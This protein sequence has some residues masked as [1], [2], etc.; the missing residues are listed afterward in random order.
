MTSTTLDIGTVI[1]I[2]VNR[3]RSEHG[4]RKLEKNDIF[5]S[6]VRMYQQD[7]V[8][9][10]IKICQLT[11]ANP[12]EV[13]EFLRSIEKN[14]P[15]YPRINDSLSAPALAKSLINYLVATISEAPKEAEVSGAP[16]ELHKVE[17][18]EPTPALHTP[19]D[20]PLSLQKLM[21]EGGWSQ[22]TLSEALYVSRNTLTDWIK[23]GVPKEQ[24]GLVKDFFKLSDE[25]EAEL[26]RPAPVGT[27]DDIISRLLDTASE[28]AHAATL[29]WAFRTR[30]GLSQDALGKMIGSAGATVHNWETHKQAIPAHKVWAIARA[31]KLSTREKECFVRAAGL[32]A[33]SIFSLR[34][35]ARH[36]D[37]L[38]AG[39]LLSESRIRIGLSRRELGELLGVSKEMVG[40]MERGVTMIPQAKVPKLITILELNRKQPEIFQ[41][42]INISNQAIQKRKLEMKNG[43]AALGATVRTKDLPLDME[44]ELVPSR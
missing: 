1:T 44:P 30:A 39:I 5:R 4:H 31:L 32:N 18:T 2:I 28:H 10:V 29:T 15:Q 40:Q 3:E 26:I 12:W 17:T 21:D 33:G 35:I 8:E 23:R 34:W 11:E 24:I 27:I 43:C 22:R 7:R 36:E 25:A 38:Q 20:T 41:E 42:V 16:L 13:D 37:H 9:T 14:F 19:A 6:Y